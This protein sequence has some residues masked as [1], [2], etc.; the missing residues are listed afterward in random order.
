[1]TV[2]GWLV[3]YNSD[4]FC[5]NPKITSE[6]FPEDFWIS[7]ETDFGIQVPVEWLGGENAEGTSHDLGTVAGMG[8]KH[9]GYFVYREEAPGA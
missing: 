1:M 2:W 7:S 3:Q 5:L 9:N 4:V 6:T 8:K